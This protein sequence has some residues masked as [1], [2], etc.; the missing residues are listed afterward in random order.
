MYLANPHATT[1][2]APAQL[3]FGRKYRTRLPQ[4]PY[5][6]IQEDICQALCCDEEQK[7]KQKERKDEKANVQPHIIEFADQVLIKQRPSKSRPPHDPEPYTV[8]EV[9]GHQI[10]AEKEGK[11][12]R[13][14]A[15]KWKVFEKRD[16][17][18]HEE[19]RVRDDIR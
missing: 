5:S 4:L 6:R 15:Q 19:D 16:K 17:P 9:S 8:T 12:I 13:G 3:L 10:T 11:S 14:N 7:G 1:Q 2:F 18:N